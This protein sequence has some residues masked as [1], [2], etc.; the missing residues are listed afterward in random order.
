MILD[1]QEWSVIGPIDADNAGF[2][3]LLEVES[4]DGERAVAKAVPKEPGAHRELLI[5]DSV[6]ASKFRNVMPVL[7]TGEHEDHWVLVMPRADYSLAQ[8]IAEVEGTFPLAKVLVVL[9]DIAGA[10]AEIDGTIVHRDLKPA[11]VL[12]YDGRWRLADFGISRYSEASTAESTRMFSFTKEYAAPEQWQHRHATGATDVYS[13]GVLAYEL[14]DGCRPF[15]GPSKADYREQH[16]HVAPAELQSGTAKLRTLIEECLYKEP[17]VRPQPR[18]LLARLRDA[19]KGADRSGA[20]KLAA[21]AHLQTRERAQEQAALSVLEEQRAQHQSK[22][23]A[24]ERALL[25]IMG[26]LRADI[27]DNAPMAKFANITGNAAPIFKVDLVEAT[28]SVGRVRSVEDWTTPFSVLAFASIGVDFGRPG[29][30]WV[31][32]SHS[33]WFCDPYEEGDYGWY[34]LAFMSSPFGA[35]RQIEP[36]AQAP[37]EAVDALQQVT[38]GTQVAWPIT[39]IDRADPEEFLERWMGWFADAAAGSLTRPSM[40]PERRF[41]SNWRR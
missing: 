25:D 40:L 37:Y 21:F 11:N 4:P 36:F 19:D 38:G 31:G 12:F 2:G 22:V 17:A 6:G 24:A 9:R 27:A 15:R 39:A 23:A 16:L 32:R 13:F 5:A 7:D 35:D 29:R 18:A 34:E 33:L 1:H 14:V 26:R 30:D 10:L 28:L 20:S 8:H 3:R 41:D